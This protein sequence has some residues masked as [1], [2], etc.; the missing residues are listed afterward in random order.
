MNVDDP[1]ADRGDATSHV[2]RKSIERSFDNVKT[3]EYRQFD[4]IRVAGA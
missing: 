3:A 4:R 2:L 1:L